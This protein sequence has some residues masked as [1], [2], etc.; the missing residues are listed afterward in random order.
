MLAKVASECHSPTVV[1]FCDVVRVRPESFTVLLAWAG[2]WPAR[3]CGDLERAA[4]A[5]RLHAVGTGA[6]GLYRHRL[7]SLPETVGFEVGRVGGVLIMLSVVE[8]LRRCRGTQLRFGGGILRF[9][10]LAH[11]R[12]DR[13]GGEYPDDNDHR[14]IARLQTRKGSGSALC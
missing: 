2:F 6:R 4:A 13:D 8:L 10:L 11:V 3:I 5:R 7:F 1:V 14:I 9:I 12:G